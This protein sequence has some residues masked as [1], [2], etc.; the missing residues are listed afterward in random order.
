MNFSFYLN[1]PPQ[2]IKNFESDPRL[3][4]LSRVEIRYTLNVSLNVSLPARGGIYKVN[5]LH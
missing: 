3:L 1:Y 4:Y 2:G 5:R